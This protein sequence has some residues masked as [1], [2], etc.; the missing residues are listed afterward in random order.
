MIVFSALVTYRYVMDA[1]FL[2]PQATTPKAQKNLT[3]QVEVKAGFCT[4]GS[5]TPS[6]LVS[7]LAWRIA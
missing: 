5:P 4:T 7:L 3:V 2:V 1:S 6:R